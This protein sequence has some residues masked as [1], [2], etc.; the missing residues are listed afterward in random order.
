MWG[1]VAH[2]AQ[3]EIPERHHYIIYTGILV[4]HAT[5]RIWPYKD[6]T[7]LKKPQLIAMQDDIQKAA[8][9]GDLEEVKLILSKTNQLEEEKKMSTWVVMFLGGFM[10]LMTLGL[11][12]LILVWIEDG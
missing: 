7:K 4:W 8:F 10:L 5:R 2:N 12:L 6:S 3:R 9:K 1:L 11:G